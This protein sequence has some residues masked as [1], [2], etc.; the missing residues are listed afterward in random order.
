MT[1]LK[2]LLEKK[3]TLL[4]NKPTSQFANLAWKTGM[5]AEQFYL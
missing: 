4:A 3:R 2:N 5:E 1:F